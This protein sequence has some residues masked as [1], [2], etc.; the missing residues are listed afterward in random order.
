MTY[1]SEFTPEVIKSDRIL[2]AIDVG[3]N[4]IHMVVA[5]I[6]PDLP[7]FTIVDRE[8]ETVRLGNFNENTKGLT[9]EAMTRAIGALKRCCAIAASYQAED[10]IAVATSA[11]REATNGPT[12]IDRVYQEV[13]LAI[14]LISGT[15]EARR[16][17]LGVLS[18]MEFQGQPHAIIDI[19]GG[20][21]ELILGT[22]E[23]HRSLSSTKVG[24]VRLT[25]QFIS[26]NPISDLEFTA[27]RAYVRGMLEPPPS[28]S[29]TS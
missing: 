8:K 13:G 6:Q 15:E 4:S 26:S 9:E 27:L 7:A 10:V 16:I 3:T 29:S 20:S 17:Y 11:V 23:P 22:G 14:N 18:G 19:G 28:S 2:A 21:T 24:A 1:L 12:F 5:K 25:A